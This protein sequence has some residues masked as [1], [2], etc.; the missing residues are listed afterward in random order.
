MGNVIGTGIYL[1]LSAVDHSCR[2]NVNVLFNGKTVELIAL[3]DI[4]SP[5]FQF[6]R[7]NY[8]TKVLPR[9]RKKL[10]DDYFFDCLCVDC[11]SN[12]EIDEMC[13]LSVVCQNINCKAPIVDKSQDLTC[14]KCGEYNT[15][16]KRTQ[17]FD[18][19]LKSDSNIIN[20][21][22]NMI[23]NLHI[24][25]YK[26]V[27]LSEKA[28]DVCLNQEK[29]GAF[30]KIA[31]KLLEAYRIYFPAKSITIGLHLAKLAKSAIYLGLGEKAHIYL[32]EAFKIFQ[33]FYKENSPFYN[34]LLALKETI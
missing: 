14:L 20:L 9:R 26:M 32:K 13:Q 19:D 29:Y 1:G 17:N 16:V 33:L 8:N 28:M 21:Y 3:D 15:N 11:V 5:A 22:E 24:Y 34:Y 4:Q 23:M 12:K 18:E 6:T 30:F 25:N 27:D 31:E 2:P 7:V 10:K